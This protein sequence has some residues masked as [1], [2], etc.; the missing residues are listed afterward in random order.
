MNFE[1]LLKLYKKTPEFVETFPL[2]QQPTYGII[3]SILALLL[4]FI[5]VNIASDK[6]KET[7]AIILLLKFLPVAI[8]A[9]I[10]SGFAIVFISNSVAVYV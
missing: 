3:T 6:K 5:S 4:I 7:N 2:D 8:L 1:E 10:V 9:S